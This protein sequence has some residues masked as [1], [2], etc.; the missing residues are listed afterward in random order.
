MR[1]SWY[2]GYVKACFIHLLIQ[3]QSILKWK[4]KLIPSNIETL[5]YITQQ[6]FPWG[7]QQFSLSAFAEVDARANNGVSRVLSLPSHI[8]I[9]SKSNT[10]TATKML[11]KHAI[12]TLKVN[13]QEALLLYSKVKYEKEI[14]QVCD[15]QMGK[16]YLMF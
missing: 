2:S 8:L 10:C 11:S 3:T 9:L 4:G 5:T 6:V 1:P 15:N 7:F 13:L 14:P 16:K 12:K